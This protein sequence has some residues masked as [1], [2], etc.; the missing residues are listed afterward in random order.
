M[1]FPHR[2]ATQPACVKQADAQLNLFPPYM[3][4]T[5]I[6]SVRSVKYRRLQRPLFLLNIIF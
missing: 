6:C 2:D 5:G 3:F 4:H 1:R